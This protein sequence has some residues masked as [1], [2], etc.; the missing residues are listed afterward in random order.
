MTGPS[1]VSL[2]GP[3]PPADAT[4]AMP[5]R[6]RS[7]R[8]LTAVAGLLALVFLATGLGKLLDLP[9]FA[10]V[11][12]DYRLFPEALLLPLAVGVTL[13]ELAIGIGLLLPGARRVAAAGA[14]LLAAGNAAVLSLT[15]LRGIPL[16]NCGCF[17]VFLARPLTAWTP[18][19]DLVLLALALLVLRWGAS[20]T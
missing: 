7:R 8:P 9:G 18:L 15:W 5:G 17:G 1:T 3:V 13:A 16:A 2:A 12:G 4:A 14:A 11:L 10:A 20:P 6:S 19:E